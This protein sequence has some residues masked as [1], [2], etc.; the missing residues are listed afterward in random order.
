MTSLES[1]SLYKTYLNFEMSLKQVSSRSK[2]AR[3]KERNTESKSG[4]GHNGPSFKA[5]MNELTE[6]LATMLEEL[7]SSRQRN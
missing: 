7:K 5:A 2:Q 1:V 4:K 6:T 3:F